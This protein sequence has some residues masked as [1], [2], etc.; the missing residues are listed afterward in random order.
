MILTCMLQTS[1]LHCQT[2]LLEVIALMEAVA[3]KVTSAVVDNAKLS[4]GMV[5]NSAT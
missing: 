5:F 4:D 1:L 2:F 3:E